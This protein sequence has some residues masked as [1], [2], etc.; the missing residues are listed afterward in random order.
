MRICY[1]ALSLTWKAVRGFD[2][3]TSRTSL[4]ISSSIRSIGDARHEDRVRFF[5]GQD[6]AALVS[7]TS[8][9][10]APLEHCAILFNRACHGKRLMHVSFWYEILRIAR[11]H[12]TG[13]SPRRLKL[14][15]TVLKARTSSSSPRRHFPPVPSDSVS[16]SALGQLYL[17]FR[18]LFLPIAIRMIRLS[19]SGISS[20]ELMLATPGAQCQLRM[21]YGNGVTDI[22]Q[23]QSVTLY[24]HVS[25]NAPGMR[26]KRWGVSRMGLPRMPCDDV[27]VIL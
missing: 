8:A 18:V 3:P 19:E 11:S 14:P 22:E 12:S 17:C 27:V 13:Y 1:T 10:R 21:G 25:I 5:D 16:S 6:S 4:L 9:P 15:S 7:C 26:K 24:H 20:L 2:K 23:P